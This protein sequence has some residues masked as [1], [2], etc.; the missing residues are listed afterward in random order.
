[1]LNVISL[2]SCA[3]LLLSCPADGLSI[4]IAFPRPSTSA[5]RILFTTRRR[6]QT[7]NTNNNT[8]AQRRHGHHV[9]VA[10]TTSWALR[11]ATNEEE[12]N[13]ENN[14]NLPALG[15]IET[16]AAAAE[17][18]QPNKIQSTPTTQ[19]QSSATTATTTE[20][21]PT[22][23]QLMSMMGTSPRR[24]FLSAASSTAIAL[25]ANFFGVTSNLLEVLP[26]EFSEKTGKRSM[27]VLFCVLE[28]YDIRYDMN[29]IPYV[30]YSC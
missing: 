21:L 6:S 11:S 15:D 20:L 30:L 2:I 4:S 17:Q 25:S 13:N 12:T 19:T 16:T 5:R 28:R 3:V 10:S 24:V 29:S 8:P 14:S 1:M 18:T 7:C 26:E 22:P 23:T 27:I 9:D